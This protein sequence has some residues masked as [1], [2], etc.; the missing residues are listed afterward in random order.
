VELETSARILEISSLTDRVFLLSSV[1]LLMV[2]WRSYCF[3]RVIA[4]SE[5][6]RGTDE[7]M[8]LMNCRSVISSSEVRW[9]D[10][11]M[12]KS[13][14]RCRLTLDSSLHR[15]V[16]SLEM[17]LASVMMLETLKSARSCSRNLGVDSI[18]R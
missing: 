13:S 16:N 10:S 5:M 11:R 18:V 14:S 7:I 9:I 1:R 12:R 8:A 3:W 2:L 15:R 6:R 4:N 17:D